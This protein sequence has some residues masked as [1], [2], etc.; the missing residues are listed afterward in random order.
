LKPPFGKQRNKSARF[1][2]MFTCHSTV[3]LKFP[4]RQN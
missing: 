2:S 3:Q 4:D 1:K